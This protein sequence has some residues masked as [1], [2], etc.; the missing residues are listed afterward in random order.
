M[1]LSTRGGRHLAILGAGAILI[2][3]VTIG[4]V[5]AIYRMKTKLKKTRLRIRTLSTRILDRSISLSL[6]AILKS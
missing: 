5:L 4:H 3:G 2:A 6:N 1:S